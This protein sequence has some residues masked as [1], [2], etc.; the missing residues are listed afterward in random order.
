MSGGVDS[1]VAAALLIEQGHDVTAVFM[2]NWSGD[3]LGIDDQCPWEEDM[4]YAQ[5]VADKLGI[6]FVSYNFEKE[7]RES[8]I[9]NF[10]EEYARGN[11]PNPDIL[12]NSSIKFDVFLK[13]AIS[14]GADLIATGHY[15]R[16]ENGSLYR[17]ADSEKD[18]T[19]FLSGLSENQL[20]KSTFPL[21]SLRKTEVR[22]I[23]TKLDLPTAKRR[24]SQG[25][26]FV[27]KI[28]IQEFLMLRLKEKKGEIVDIDTNEVMGVHNG[29]WFHTN[30]QR[31]GL[32][33][34]GLSEPYFVADKDVEKNVVYVAQGRD[35]PRLWSDKINTEDFQ[36]INPDENLEGELNAQI[37]YRSKLAA[38]R[39]NNGSFIFEEPQWAPAR[40]QSLV[41]YRGDRCLGRGLIESWS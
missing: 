10:Y 39:F 5:K 4:E 32:K 13:R 36:L 18:Q 7:Y 24:D 29:V 3:D 40:G 19:Y 21:S 35:N 28:D 33:I 20:I 38:V 8:V 30:G 37:R 16:T 14:D 9:E 6:P 34:G 22:E 26:C 23:A 25:I 2:K 12:C 27:G 1:S 41:I 11:T 15:A 31:K 17:A